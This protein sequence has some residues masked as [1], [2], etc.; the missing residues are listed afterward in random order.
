MSSLPSSLSHQRL[1]DQRV[2]LELHAR[3][4]SLL[5]RRGFAALRDQ[6]ERASLSIVLNIAEGAGRF[7]LPDKRRFYE[8]AHGSAAE[9][10]AILE[11]LALREI[12]PVRQAAEAHALSV[13]VG[14][15]LSRLSGPPR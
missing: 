13:R 11:V 4:S 10:A 12:V 6:L 15:M 5:P 2:A 8:I 14:R 7:S 3:A 9:T 1:E